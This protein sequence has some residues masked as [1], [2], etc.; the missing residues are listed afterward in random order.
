MSRFFGARIRV[1]SNCGTCGEPIDRLD[2]VNELGVPLPANGDAALTMQ[3]MK[4]LLFRT[5]RVQDF[6]CPA[7]RDKLREAASA[8]A[9]SAAH[10]RGDVHHMAT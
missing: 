7:C 9:I 8:K 6:H 5:D 2:A 3:Q 1:R 4:G 10:D